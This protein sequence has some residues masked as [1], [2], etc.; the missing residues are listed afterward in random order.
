[1][2][3]DDA[4]AVLLPDIDPATVA[5]VLRRSS[6]TAPQEQMAEMMAT[7]I[8][9]GAANGYDHRPIDPTLSNLSTKTRRQRTLRAHPAPQWTR[10]AAPNQLNSYV[11]LRT[12]INVN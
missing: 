4:M 8:N 7:M 10:L 5:R 1:L 6:Y 3:P 2:T 9:E 12:L 11:G